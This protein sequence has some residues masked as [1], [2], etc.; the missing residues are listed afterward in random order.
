M[1]VINELS[2]YLKISRGRV[3]K[4]MR[5]REAI[6]ETEYHIHVATS[7]KKNPIDFYR[8]SRFMMF[9][10]AQDEIERDKDTDWDDMRNDLSHKKYSSILDFGAGIGSAGIQLSG[11]TDD[12]FF[13]EPNIHALQF[14][15]HRAKNRNL[16]FAVSSNF[17]AMHKFDLIVAWGVFEHIDDDLAAH[18]FKTLLS[19][20]NPNGLFFLKNF[21]EQTDEYLLHFKKGTKM[22]QLYK[23]HEDKIIFAR[24]SH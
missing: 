20:L 21:Y 22:Q 15:E 9:S 1:N 11:M 8:S 7:N 2:E 12:I 17:P 5:S 16:N 18:Y 24:H 14:L 23:K 13:Y 6:L 4:M 10:N 3:K 19:M